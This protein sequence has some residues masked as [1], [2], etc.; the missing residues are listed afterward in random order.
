MCDGM[1]LELNIQL[2]LNMDTCSGTSFARRVKSETVLRARL[3]VRSAT[4][5]FG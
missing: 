2:Q 4:E 1:W 5:L 3:A